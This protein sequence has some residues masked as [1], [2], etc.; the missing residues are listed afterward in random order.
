MKK[1]LALLL[2]VMMTVSTLAACGANNEDGGGS[3]VNSGNNTAA[4]DGGNAS[5]SGGNAAGAKDSV[6]LCV[7][8]AISTI[9]PYETL[10]YTSWYVFNNVYETLIINDD[11]GVTQPC[12]AT[13][14]VPSED[15]LTYTFT[16][17]DGAKFHDGSAFTA[18][19]AA[20][21]LTEAKKHAAM[22]IYTNM[23]ESA[24]AADDTTLTVTL[25]RPYASF[26]S[27]MS[28]IPMVSKEYYP[29][30]DNSTTALGTGPYM[31]ESYD[32]NNEVVLTAFA[33]YRLGEP[34]IKTVNMKV[35]S[36]A[37]T[38]VVALESGD[39]DFL[40]LYNMSAYAGLAANDN[41]ET[42]LCATLHTAYQSLNLE[43]APLDN[44]LLRQALSYAI[45]YE[46]V[47]L[48][49]YEGLA[50]RAYA[51]MGENA[52]GA[53]FTDMVKYE[54]DPEKAADLLAQAGFA[55]GLNFSDYGI[56]YSY[57]PGGYHEKI[58][59]CIQQNWAEIGVTVELVANENVDSDV[60][61]GNFQIATEGGTYT[62]DMA[63]MAAMYATSG[64]GSNNYSRYSNPRVDELFELADAT[65]DSAERAAYYKEI[66]E[67]TAEDALC[68]PIQ[69]KQIPYIWYK[70]LNAVVHLSSAH[71]WY[72]YEWSWN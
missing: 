27:L 44:K 41:F 9:D 62:S 43:V 16:L 19:D 32:G 29:S 65:T 1:I 69:H 49:A 54:Y 3:D 8:G 17:V 45:D 48:V 14:W 58:A 55:G 47:I 38:A 39:L 24:E 59:Q 53:D 13:S 71:P 50:V 61:A 25:N 2:A 6:A 67:I 37:S 35:I 70:D 33:G 40:T 60:P 64:I 26:V 12:L 52:F 18:E 72:V 4:P 20:Y 5:S 34:A 42:Q 23:I 63:F 10:A 22:S 15:G 68:I 30:S 66:C 31:I 57:I 36:D 7:E 11:D 46:N 51:L 28:E 56:Q 21:S